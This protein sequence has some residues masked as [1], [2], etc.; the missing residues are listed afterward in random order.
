M[1]GKEENQEN[2]FMRRRCFS[3][4]GMAA[5]IK[6]TSDVKEYEFITLECGLEV[7]LVSSTALTKD[8]KKPTA[9]AA[10]AVQ[11]GSFADPKH[12]GEHHSHDV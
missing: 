11:V 7:L 12:A 1:R 6:S 8:G 9:A 4:Q 2:A 5:I 3:F 10:M